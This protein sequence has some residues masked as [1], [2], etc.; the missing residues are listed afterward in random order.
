MP[1]LVVVNGKTHRSLNSWN[2]QE[3]P[4][5]TRWAFQ[6]NGYM[7]ED[8]GVE[9]LRS[10]F[11]PNCGTHRPQLLI[12]DGHK[13]HTSLNLLMLAK[14]AGIHLL[15]LPPHSTHRLQPLDKGV[16]RSLK[17]N[18]NSK[19]S[20]FLADSFNNQINHHTWPHIFHYAFDKSMTTSNIVNAFEASG[21]HP[22]NPKK[23]LD[24]SKTNPIPNHP[25]PINLTP[26]NIP[27]GNVQTPNLTPGKAQT[28]VGAATVVASDMIPS[29]AQ[30]LVGIFQ[31]PEGAHDTST[32]S[33][34]NNSFSSMDTAIYSGPNA[35]QIK[36]IRV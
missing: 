24:E 30:A 22:F 11:L 16:F 26:S 29:A 27:S 1:P 35:S 5:G 33:A 8:L 25:I 13:S 9:W 4:S 2:V 19:C 7:T 10:V 15:A 3:G 28:P 14:E 17:S 31:N 6:D 20:E 32:S 12:L 34:L 23:I 18:Y 36:S 21:L